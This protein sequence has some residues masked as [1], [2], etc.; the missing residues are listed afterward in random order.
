MN[1]IAWRIGAALKGSGWPVAVGL[2]LLCFAAAFRLSAFDALV[3]EREALQ[4]QATEARARFAI[5]K[6]H[7]EKVK[8]GSADQLRRYY[9]F[10]PSFAALP[11]LLGR[12]RGCAVSVSL[13]LDLGEY[14]LTTEK[15]SPIARYQLTFPVKGGYP[16]IR[17][18][19]REVLSQVPASSLDDVAFTRDAVAS[20]TVSA[21]IRLT[22]YLSVAGT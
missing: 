4:R 3:Q 17:A 22:L 5:V 18:F 2:A 13:P 19:I 10:F 6:A 7:P 12:I 9:Q 14:L 21:R 16:N 15:G 8:P 20:D 11:E 1:V